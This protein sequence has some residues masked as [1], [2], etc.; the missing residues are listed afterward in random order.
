MLNG[1]EE[2][3]VQM[4]EGGRDEEVAPSKKKNKLTRVTKT[5]E[6]HTL[7]GHTYL[8]R[9]YK[10]VFPSWDFDT[11]ATVH[12]RSSLNRKHPTRKIR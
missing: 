3:K 6:D 1:V 8:Y 9:P 7:W 2:G 4:G 10:G 12:G 11:P 5:A